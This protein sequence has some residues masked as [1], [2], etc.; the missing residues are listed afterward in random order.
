[1]QREFDCGWHVGGEDPRVGDSRPMHETTPVWPMYEGAVA[2]DTGENDPRNYS[3]HPD[4]VASWDQSNVAH[5]VEQPVACDPAEA[6]ASDEEYDGWAVDQLAA[7]EKQ[8]Q[9]SKRVTRSSSRF[10]KE[11]APSSV[12]ESEDW[13]LPTPVAREESAEIHAVG[14]VGR[15]P[16]MAT[17]T[18]G[19]PDYASRFTAR[20]DVDDLRRYWKYL[21]KDR[22]PRECFVGI[23]EDSYGPTTYVTRDP[24]E[25]LDLLGPDYES[26]LA[27]GVKARK[28][29][30]GDSGLWEAKI[31]AH[32]GRDTRLRPES[33]EEADGSE[34]Y[35]A[36]WMGSCPVTGRRVKAYIT[37]DEAVFRGHYIHTTDWGQR[38]NTFEDAWAY[39]HLDADDVQW[40]MDDY[41]PAGCGIRPEHCTGINSQGQ[42]VSMVGT[43]IMNRK[44]GARESSASVSAPAKQKKVP[45]KKP[46][47][48]TS[49]DEVLRSVRLSVA[50]KLA[51]KRGGEAIEIHSSSEPSSE[52][53]V[54]KRTRSAH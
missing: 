42:I 36:L 5:G 51:E 17:G 45:A 38:C 11:A 9:E 29:G 30:P 8:L 34:F 47:L 52:G 22:Y 21:A 1:M 6:W 35:Y 50:K 28:F 23:R 10:V 19:R 2:E 49:A 31:F 18:G 33:L 53:G 43:H 25:L 41:R 7:H 4:Y 14:E 40:R 26:V 20:E 13:P 39:V 16:V 15:Q 48:A 37:S 3:D 54:S 24:T 12:A 44:A 27:G 46:L 32:D